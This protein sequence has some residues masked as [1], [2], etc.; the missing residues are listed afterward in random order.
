VITWVVGRG[1]LLGQ[2]IDRACRPSDRLFDAH[3]IPWQD[4]LA[5]EE[6][7]QAEVVRFQQQAQD[8]HWRVIWAAGAATTASSDG[9]AQA[10]LAPLRALLAALRQ[11]APAGPGCAFLA[12][13]AGGVFAGSA[14]PPFDA[15]T[16]AAPIGAYGR[17]KLQQEQLFAQELVDTCPVVIGRISNLYGPGQNLAK[18]QGLVSRL[19]LAALTGQSINVFVPLDTIRDYVFADDAARQVLRLTDAAAIR[20]GPKAATP[21]PEAAQ[22]AVIAS[23]RPATVGQLLQV[24]RL[25]TRRRIP[26]AF[27]SHPSA[28]SQAADLRLTPTL[29]PDRLTPLPAGVKTVCQD[30]LHRLQLSPSAS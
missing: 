10:E 12:S 7:L 5:A 2:A 18:L 6:V 15:D 22:V 14:S 21:T 29:V 28:V 4:P 30:M 8:S 27:G 23:G 1:G 9:E 26:V 13:S 17:L 19:V 20:S 24:T 11:H 3:P 16:P 25:V